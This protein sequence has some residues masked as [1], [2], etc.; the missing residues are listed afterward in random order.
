[1]WTDKEKLKL[2]TMWSA[3]IK[4]IQETGNF[5]NDNNHGPEPFFKSGKHGHWTPHEMIQ[6]CLKYIKFIKYGRR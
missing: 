4:E 1:M 2:L 6:Y 3:R 5:M